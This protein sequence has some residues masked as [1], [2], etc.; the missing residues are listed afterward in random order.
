MQFPPAGS[1]Q[2]VE[3]GQSIC[4]RDAEV[5]MLKML[6]RERLS[7]LSKAIGCTGCWYCSVLCNPNH[8]T[9][10]IPLI[11]DYGPCFGDIFWLFK[12]RNSIIFS[13][14]HCN[15]GVCKIANSFAPQLF[16]GRQHSTKKNGSEARNCLK[17][18]NNFFLGNCL[19]TDPIEKSLASVMI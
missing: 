15:T 14:K 5:K 16:S 11:G 6:K 4:P 18:T 10:R 13:R 1:L 17:L 2:F 8:F 3:G 9:A 12:S 19:N 7:F